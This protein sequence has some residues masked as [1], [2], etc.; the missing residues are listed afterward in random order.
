MTE[1]KKRE[2]G[3]NFSNKEV[4]IL[5]SIIQ[6]FKNIIECKK[7]DATTWRD[8]DAAWENVA[9][10]FN[11]SSGEVFRL[12]KALKAKYEDIKKNVKKKLA[13]N[14]L[15]TFKT[16]GGEP[17]IRSLTGIEEN[18]I[19]MLP[20]S[21]EGLPSVWDSDQLETSQKDAI[22]VGI[23]QHSTNA[24]DTIQVDDT[25]V[26]MISPTGS[27]DEQFHM[28]FLI[29]SD[30]ENNEENENKSDN[31]DCNQGTEKKRYET[32]V[33]ML[34]KK[35]TPEL[36]TGKRLKKLHQPLGMHE[37]SGRDREMKEELHQL[38]INILKKEL[39]IK[40][41]QFFAE[42]EIN[43]ERLKTAKVEGEMRVLQKQIKEAKLKK[44]HCYVTINMAI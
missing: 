11:S 43:T 39:E 31:Q 9:K 37:T 17:Q 38:R 4:E 16:G 13:H 41:K 2:R 10:A 19:S 33:S 44:L 7:T 24:N 21:I 22:N 42:I 40:E 28:E 35:I 14:R 30:K 18:I 6:E 27:V 25:H 8:K 23:Q 3:S 15:E 34:K 5:V 26:K 12:K 1:K 32:G 29:T 36:R 20:S